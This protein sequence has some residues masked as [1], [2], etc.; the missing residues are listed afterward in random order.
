MKT[1]VLRGLALAGA[2]I[3]AAIPAAVPAQPAETQTDYAA[4]FTD[5]YGS[6]YPYTGTLQLHIGSDGIVSGYYRP[7][8]T[9]DFVPVTGGRDGNAIWFDIGSTANA[10]THVNATLAGGSM[11][12]TAYDR[13]HQQLTFRATP[14]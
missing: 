2:L 7:A 11:S 4:A 13:D 9:A 8:D 12:G 14:Q 1:S 3:G 5:L 10:L 6:Q